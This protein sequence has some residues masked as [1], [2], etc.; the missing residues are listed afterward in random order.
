MTISFM[1]KH[2]SH[3]TS[4]KCTTC[5]PRPQQAIEAGVSL[6][7]IANDFFS[8][9]GR[10]R[11]CPLLDADGGAIDGVGS[12]L[13]FRLS[14]VSHFAQSTV[15]RIVKR[16]HRRSN[17]RNG[18]RA[19]AD[20]Q[21]RVTFSR[22]GDVDE[23]DHCSCRRGGCW[24]LCVVVIGSFEGFRRVKWRQDCRLPRRV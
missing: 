11:R 4:R 5:H 3:A 16:F 15:W 19:A 23:A 22:L 6:K 9:Y 18:R 1:T 2:V 24:Q 12:G 7:K 8:Q 13:H 14:S 17:P 10:R 21:L 20:V